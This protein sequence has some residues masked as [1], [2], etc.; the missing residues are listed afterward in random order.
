MFAS[1]GSDLDEADVSRIAEAILSPS[2][3]AK[4]ESVLKAHE[5]SGKCLLRHWV[6]YS[7]KKN[8]S[9]KFNSPARDLYSAVLMSTRL[10][11]Y[12]TQSSLIL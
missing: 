1:D 5:K 3:A 6:Y 4:A 11:K 9:A 12:Q 10:K 2:H 7:S 8:G